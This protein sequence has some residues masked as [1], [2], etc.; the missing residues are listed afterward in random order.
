MAAAKKVK[1][2]KIEADKFEE[3]GK[4]NTK[5]KIKEFIDTIMDLDAVFFATNYL[6]KAGFE[7]FKETFVMTIVCFTI[8]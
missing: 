1:Y 6:A 2:F 3:I 4:M 7:V 8:H 5:E